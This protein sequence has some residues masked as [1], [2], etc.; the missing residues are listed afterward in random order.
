M[1][2]TPFK[3]TGKIYHNNLIKIK[4]KRKTNLKMLNEINNKMQIF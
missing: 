3:K 4:R 1:K 2:T